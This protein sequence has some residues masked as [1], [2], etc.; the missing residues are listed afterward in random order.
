MQRLWLAL[1]AV[2][3]LISVALSALAAH[4][5]T[6]AARTLMQEGLAMQLPH[7]L[8]LLAVGLW[9]PR[10]GRLADAAGAGFALGSVLF[11]GELY[12]HAA[13]GIA[14]GVAAPIGGTLLMA[15]WLL[16]ARS[17]A[18]RLP[19]EAGHRPHDQRRE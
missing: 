19:G 2:S 6:P 17:A 7:A 10:G 5:L 18:R 15:G 11:C 3:G 8:A 9:A 14:L 16:L 12:F 4:A 13:A 1:G